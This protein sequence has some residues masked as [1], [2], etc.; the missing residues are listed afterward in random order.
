M[1]WN[2]KF[3]SNG[4]VDKLVASHVDP[5]S[6]QPELKYTPVQIQKADPLWYGFLLTRR[7]IELPELDYWSRSL[8]NGYIRYEIAGKFTPDDWAKWARQC[9]CRQ[10]N[11]V[12]WVEYHDSA[13]R[14]YRSARVVNDRLESCLFVGPTTRLPSR[15]WLGQ[16]FAADC[17]GEADKRGL[18]LG[19]SVDARVDAGSL[20]CACNQ[21]GQ[22]TI[23][24]L[25]NSG[26]ATTVQAIGQA[27]GAGTSCGSC[28]AEI[29]KML[30]GG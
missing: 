23:M 25:I 4:S 3:A 2:E 22:N 18:M 11:D 19:R 20:V 29:Q 8:G 16:L 13:T 24:K 30:Q 26:E 9:L 6:G 10:E 17:L 12:H 21:V 5:F 14:H 27:C 28:V 1:H 7:Q 15:E